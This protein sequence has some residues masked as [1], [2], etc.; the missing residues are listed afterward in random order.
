MQRRLIKWGLIVLGAAVVLAAGLASQF[1]NEIAFRL[2]T[3]SVPYSEMPV[4]PRPVYIFLDAWVAHPDKDDFADLV[5]EG[6]GISDNQS[7][8]QAD[9][10]FVHPTTHF[11]EDWNAEYNDAAA[12]A[13]ADGLVMS[14]QASVFNGCCRV[15][16]PRYRQAHAAAFLQPSANGRSALDLAYVDVLRA[17]EEYLR[18]WNDGRPIIIAGHSQ[19]A[20]MAM[21]L[22]GDRMDEP[23]LR[24]LLVGAYII[25]AGVPLDR[26]ESN[27]KSITACE[28][29]TD[30]GCV[31]SWETYVDGADPF[32]TPNIL[33]VWYDRHWVTLA[34]GGRNCT[35]P[36]SWSREP[37]R[38][39]ANLNLGAIPVGPGVKPGLGFALGGTPNLDPADFAT[40]PAPIP[41]LTW[42]ECRDGF[43]FVEEPTEPVLRTSILGEGNLH[44][45]DF[46]LFYMNIRQNAQD[47]VDA[48]FGA[49]EQRRG[50]D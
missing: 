30:I 6:L 36:L 26:F 23:P 38:A 29:A 17:F 21:R 10:F 42:A 12:S 43:L 45:Y 33:E 47:R 25:G 2:M 20:V 3:P 13:I 7:T 15:F 44:A 9:V 46:A 39:E 8:A 27:W 19:G 5:P 40:I 4:L 22:L 16:S 41:G 48:Y 32:A 18:E 14:A 11:G 31:V 49:G 24:A 35:N 28:S 1:Q 37:G 34:N 50:L